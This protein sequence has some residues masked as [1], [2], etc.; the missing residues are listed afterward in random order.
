MFL[1]F[2][3]KYVII[4]VCYAFK[5]LIWGWLKCSKKYLIFTN[6]STL[7]KVLLNLNIK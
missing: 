7:I 6:N 5:L 2:T 3:T 1:K 4:V